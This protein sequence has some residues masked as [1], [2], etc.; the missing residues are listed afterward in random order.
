S[1]K[2]ATL[3][4]T[5]GRPWGKTALITEYSVRDIQ[6]PPLVREY[7]QTSA[8]IG[9]RRKFDNRFAIAQALRPWG[10]FE[11]RP[12]TRW[13][14]LGAVALSRGAGFHLYDNVQG[15]FLVSYVKPVQHT[16]SAVDGEVPV[17]YPL[18]FSV[19]VQQQTF[20]GFTG[21]G[22]ATSIVPVIR[23]SLF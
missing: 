8:G 13:S 6:F 20:Y 21:R 18:R 16:L 11:Y 7:Y 1:D 17:A 23:L 19:G 4:F 22:S 14:V 10:R 3:Q 12:N 5:V 9:L 15:E 2:T